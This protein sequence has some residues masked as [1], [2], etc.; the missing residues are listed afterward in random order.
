MFVPRAS[1]QSGADLPWGPQPRLTPSGVGT[2]LHRKNIS[3]FNPFVYSP[4]PIVAVSLGPSLQ[5]EQFVYSSPH[6]NKSWE[7]FEEMITTAEDFYQSL[8]IPYH[9]VNIVSGIR[10]PVPHPTNT[11]ATR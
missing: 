6:D 1:V 2:G 4:C 7:M 9:I 10:L 8:G 5:I 3:H 11:T